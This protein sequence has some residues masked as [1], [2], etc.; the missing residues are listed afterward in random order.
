MGKEQQLIDD[1]DADDVEIYTASLIAA[2]A[3]AAAA[4]AVAA[5]GTRG[6]YRDQAP[7]EPRGEWSGRATTASSWMDL[8]DYRGWLQGVERESKRDVRPALAP[9]GMAEAGSLSLA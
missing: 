4:A 6:K 1:C 8:G 9:A 7:V 3:A 2:T 5:R